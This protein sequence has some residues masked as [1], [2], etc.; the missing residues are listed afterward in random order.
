MINLLDKQPVYRWLFFVV[1]E[2]RKSLN[3]SKKKQA[4]TLNTLLMLTK[5]RIYLQEA[6]HLMVSHGNKKEKEIGEK[7]DR[8]LENNLVT[9]AIDAL[10]PDLSLEAYQALKAGCYA[11]DIEAG[12]RNAIKA[13]KLSDSASWS[14]FKHLFWPFIGV[15]V[16]CSVTVIFSN[17]VMPIIEDIIDVDSLPFVVSVADT[18]GSLFAE[19]GLAL[20]SLFSLALTVTLFSLPFLTGE[21]RER[22]DNMPIFKQYR[23]LLSTSFL[24][25]LTDQIRS[26]IDLDAALTQTRDISSPYLANHIQKMLGNIEQGE[27][28]LGEILNTGLL[29]DEQAQ[30]LRILG[31][32]P[33]YEEILNSSS[34]IHY[35]KL[36]KTIETVKVQGQ[37]FIKAFGFSLIGLTLIA[38]ILSFL[39]IRASV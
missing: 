36:M 6:A 32:T 33:D 4:S 18:L 9:E 3:W 16:S 35:E 12:L 1:R 23:I 5:N 21:V 19:M 37:G 31:K 8:H 22:L 13:L 11:N 10:E 26:D 15:I 29:L 7:L 38:I 39:A 2:M 24:R 28:N 25:S 17:K 30:V 34:E 14:L 20:L 27:S